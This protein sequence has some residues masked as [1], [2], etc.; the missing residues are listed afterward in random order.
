MVDFLKF[1]LSTVCPGDDYNNENDICFHY[2]VYI[3]V[4]SNNSPNLHTGVVSGASRKGSMASPP[5]PSTQS[6]VIHDYIFVCVSL[7]SSPFLE[8]HASTP[9][10]PSSFCEPILHIPIARAVDFILFS[11]LLNRLIATP[12]SICGFWCQYTTSTTRVSGVEYLI[13]RSAEVLW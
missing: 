9:F 12:T 8:V 7:K 6:L 4:A 1:V 2:W 13:L 5:V 3:S 10:S 11:T